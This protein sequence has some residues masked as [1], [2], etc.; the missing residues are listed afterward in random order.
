MMTRK[1][2]S[3]LQKYSNIQLWESRMT[4]GQ[5]RVLSTKFLG[6][7]HRQRKRQAK[8]LH[9]RYFEKTSCIITI[10]LSLT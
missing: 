7:V 5:K 2:D 3:R 8:G 1:V 4:A 10:L 9:W 6:D